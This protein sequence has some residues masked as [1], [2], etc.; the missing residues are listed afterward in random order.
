MHRPTSPKLKQHCIR[1]SK[2][3][4]TTYLPTTASTTLWSTTLRGLGASG[5]M[6]LLLPRIYYSARSSCTWS[7]SPLL[8]LICAAARVKRSEG[9]KAKPTARDIQ[10]GMLPCHVPLRFAAGPS[11]SPWHHWSALRHHRLPQ[12][13][14]THPRHVPSSRDCPCCM[15]TIR[16]RPHPAIAS[17]PRLISYKVSWKLHCSYERSSEGMMLSRMFRNTSIRKSFCIWH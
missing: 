16:S 1:T 10:H 3:C 4:P 8:R 2:P 17:K 13:P 6:Y 11:R 15:L 14:S 9:E 7:P 5:I 12:N